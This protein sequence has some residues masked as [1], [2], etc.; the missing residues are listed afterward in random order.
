MYF[1]L[2]EEGRGHVQ[3]LILSALLMGT[4]FFLIVV[5][6]LAD[7]MGVNRNL[8][9]RLDWRV[10]KIEEKFEHERKPR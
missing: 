9:E 1:F 8:L 5:G 7:L 2:T 6:L 3:S 4:G 10:Q